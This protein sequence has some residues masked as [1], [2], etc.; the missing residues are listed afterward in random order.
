[1]TANIS[2]VG[3]SQFLDVNGNP[4]SGGKLYTY[5][6]GTTTPL[7]AYT[8]AE[9]DVPQP[10]PVILNSLG[11]LDDPLYLANG[12]AYKII[13]KT[14]AG[15][16]LGLEYDDIY[17]VAAADTTADEWL[18]FTGTFTYV[19]STSFTVSGDQTSIFQVSR[20]LKTQNTAGIAYSNIASATYSAPDT[21]VTVTNTFL[22]LDS[23]LSQI[24][25][26]FLEPTHSSIPE[27]TI[28]TAVRVGTQVEAQSALGVYSTTATD[29]AIAAASPPQLRSITVVAVANDLVITINPTKVDFRSTTLTS[30]APTS[31]T[32]ASAITLTVPNGATLGT[33]SNVKARLPVLCINN[34]GTGEVAVG[35]VAGGANFDE[36]GVITTTTISTGADSATVLYSTTGRTGVAYKLMGYADITQTSAG[37]WAA[38]PALVV[39]AGDDLFSKLTPNVAFSA[40]RTS[41]Q[42]FTSSANTKVQCQTEDYDDG[43]CYDN[44]TNYR[45]TAPVNGLYNLTGHVNYRGSGAAV[46]EAY[47]MLWKNGADWKRGNDVNI[48][49]GGTRGVTVSASSV[50]LAAGDYVELYSYGVCASAPAIATY[51]F[52][53]GH[54]IRAINV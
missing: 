29:A 6:A 21:T 26:G 43:G 7:A 32:I 53:S 24:W 33:S 20:K 16:S 11:T 17:G 31:V 46:T 4:L 13:V 18:E 52:F 23:G 14:S 12:V 47:S 44:A 27:T 8:T 45:F 39:P 37:V 15:V 50:Y 40:R 36:S 41:S 19:S 9:G 25:Y 51:S 38:D 34:D 10:N 2:P 48:T 1:M 22:T 5:E 42:S 30:G 49:S 28:G 54:L 3:N 35:N